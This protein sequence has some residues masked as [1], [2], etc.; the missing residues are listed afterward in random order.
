MSLVSLFFAIAALAGLGSLGLAWR[1]LLVGTQRNQ[2]LPGA[3]QTVEL[4]APMEVTGDAK[5]RF[6][7]NVS[8]ELRTPLAGILGMADL[9]AATPISGEQ[10]AY[11]EAIRNSGNALSVLIDEILDFSRIEAGKLILAREP[12]GIVALVE[13]VV[14][15]LAPQA[16]GKSLEIASLV[17]A[18]VP[19]EW[20]GDVARL[21]QILLNLVG[22]AVKF[23]TKG[24]VGVKVSVSNSGL[25]FSIADTGCGVPRD[26]QAAIFEEFEQADGS[27]TQI[28][29]GSGLGLTIARQLVNAMGGRLELTQSSAKGSIF[30]FI[31]PWA[32]GAH[33]AVKM[34]SGAGFGE[35]P[36]LVVANSQFEAPYLAAHLSGLGMNV[37]C[38]T[39]PNAA[40]TRLK[41]APVPAV[42]IV[43]GGLGK[44]AVQALVFA[45]H[46][47]GVQK[48]LILLSPNER[49]LYGATLSDG[50]EGWLIKPM[51]QNSI[52]QRLGANPPE[53]LPLVSPLIAEPVACNLS[54]LLAEDNDINAL[55]ASRQ[56]Q[57]LGAQV[58]R[59][60]DGPTALAM[61]CRASSGEAPAFDLILMD[62]RM[63]G[64]D[65]REVTRAIRRAE[66]DHGKPPVK[67][68][69]LTANGHE[70]E[71][72]S[73]RDAGIDGF[74]TKPVDFA[75]LAALLDNLPEQHAGLP[76]NKAC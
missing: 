10:G 11:I 60:A 31:L 7:A 65:G 26:R 22:N 13:G 38:A 28:H 46:M 71:R 40:L 55:V 66:V 70:S 14:E 20:P 73:S 76:L 12:V 9:L 25:V 3:Q 75:V 18:E 5:S 37:I 43:D 56:L 19:D 74:L 32:N 29:G 47:A 15:L 53:R 61:A 24:G 27:T 64:L 51:R 30:R 69:A 4:P 21:R 2:E 17:E 23:T 59:A 34:P 52:L 54:V 42:L 48:R 6:L 62:L 8:H 35:A 68:I 45:A 67:I 57:R 44:H 1:Y 72:Q 50:F 36:V 63:P 16:Q 58:I 41:S 39:D 33:S 49:R